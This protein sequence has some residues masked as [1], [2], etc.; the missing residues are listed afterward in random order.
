MSFV[1][2]N[3]LPF[4][5][6][7]LKELFYRRTL[8]CLWL[9]VIFFSLFT[10]LDFFACR[11][12]FGL[13]F[14]YRIVYVLAVIG[15]IN[16]LTLPKCKKYAPHLIYAGMVLGG[17]AISLMTVQLGGFYSGYYVGILLMIAGALSVLP[18]RVSEVIFI[19]MSM[20]VIYIVTVL[21]GTGNTSPDHLAAM[22]N[23]SFF[24]LSLVA[25]TALQSHDDLL[26]LLKSIRASKS[27]QSIR[28]E[29]TNYTGGLE[30]LVLKRL[31]DLEESDV[32]YQDLYDSITDLV[33]L[34]DSRGV[35]KKINQHCVIM[36]GYGPQQLEEKYFSYF[37]HGGDRE[38]AQVGLVIAKLSLG[39]AMEGIQLQLENSS[40]QVLDTELSGNRV[41]V[42]EDVFFQFVIRDISATKAMEMQVL[43]SERLIGTSRQAAILGLAKLAECR[44]DDTGAHLNRIRLYTDILI[45][46]LATLPEYTAV[47]TE[48]FIEDILRS[49]VLHDIGKVGTPDSIL[50]KPGRLTKEEFEEMKNHCRYGSDILADTQKEGEEGSFLML[51]KD[52]ARHHHERW[53]GKGYPDGLAKTD[54][55][56][57]ARVVALADVYD[58]LTSTRVYKASYNHEEAKELIVKERGGQFDPAVV[59][60]FLAT[61][62]EFKESRMQELL[63]ESRKVS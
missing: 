8:I 21:L 49:S 23:N 2:A 9:A 32:K 48:G 47:I 37:I 13:F 56:F 11:E 6:G 38:K 36:L 28:R 55:P 30:N 59:D 12:H 45:Q 51:A 61:E 35:I 52:I 26:N 29:L 7:D 44:D 4:F 39:E 15:F 25:I 41:E 40:G 50:L 53:D 3:A 43:E 14:M 34:V 16:I 20:Y 24:F 10:V 33:V 46:H 58:A 31:Q 18:L 22:L 54:I 60:A 63:Q 19:G 27:L 57:A 62:V 17:L 5:K 1:Q 42:G